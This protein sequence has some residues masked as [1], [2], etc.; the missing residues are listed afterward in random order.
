M[1]W[2]NGFIVFFRVY[3]LSVVFSFWCATSVGHNL[4]I[5]H[6]HSLQLWPI[7][8]FGNLSLNMWFKIHDDGDDVV[9]DDRIDSMTCTSDSENLKI[10]SFKAGS[11]FCNK[12]WRKTNTVIQ[13]AALYAFCVEPPNGSSCVVIW[14]IGYDFKWSICLHYRTPTVLSCILHHGKIFIRPR[15]IHYAADHTCKSLCSLI[16]A[17]CTDC[18][19]MYFVIYISHTIQLYILYR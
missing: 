9:F 3:K 16:I 18:T 12:R 15:R 10:H 2:L 8:S 4:W 7:H 13:C 17:L 11:Q 1:K 19:T 14:V 5:V 6:L